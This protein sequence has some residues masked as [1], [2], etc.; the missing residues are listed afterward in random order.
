ME[1]QQKEFVELTGLHHDLRVIVQLVNKQARHSEELTKAAINLTEVLESHLSAERGWL[2][3]AL[4][5]LTDAIKNS[6]PN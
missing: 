6:A 1:A 2:H 3:D 5:Q 4:S